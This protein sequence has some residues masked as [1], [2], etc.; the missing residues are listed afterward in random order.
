MFQTQTIFNIETLSCYTVE[1]RSKKLNFRSRTNII[2]NTQLFSKIQHNLAKD[3]E[4]NT[5]IQHSNDNKTI[6]RISND[7]CPEKH[8]IVNPKVAREK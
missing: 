5:Q 7:R 4:Q 2:L 8:T 1:K 3:N 6:K